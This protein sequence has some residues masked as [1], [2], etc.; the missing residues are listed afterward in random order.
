M[1]SQR[2]IKEDLRSLQSISIV[3]LTRVNMSYGH[4]YLE[5][6]F[7][8]VD[9]EDEDEQGKLS[10]VVRSTRYSGRERGHLKSRGFGSSLNSSA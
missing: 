7:A 4:L 6:A 5:S 2:T 1:H 3:Y 8:V 10:L 9:L